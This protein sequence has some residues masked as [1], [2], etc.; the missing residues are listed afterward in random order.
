MKTSLL[1][2]DPQE[3]RNTFKLNQVP[4]VVFL[5]HLISNSPLLSLPS[6]TQVLSSLSISSFGQNPIVWFFLNSTSHKRTTYSLA[7]FDHELRMDNDS[8]TFGH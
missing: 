5:D 8:F 4:E 7:S 2:P 6:H 3:Q 1:D